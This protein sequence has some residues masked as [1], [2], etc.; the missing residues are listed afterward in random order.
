MA[1][2]ELMVK[3]IRH[4]AGK[5]LVFLTFGTYL[6]Y[7][8]SKFKIIFYHIIN[9]GNSKYLALTLSSLFSFFPFLGGAVSVYFMHSEGYALTYSILFFSPVILA[10]LLFFL[11]YFISYRKYKYKKRQSENKGDSG[12]Q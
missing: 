4:V 11:L 12:S 9:A 3:K 6:I 2:A 8:L 7:G 1:S 10:W 5:I